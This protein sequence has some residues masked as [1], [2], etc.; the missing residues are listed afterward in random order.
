MESDKTREIAKKGKS[1]HIHVSLSPE[2]LA[3]LDVIRGDSGR[4]TLIK[5]AWLRFLDEVADGH[6]NPRRPRQFLAA[7]GGSNGLS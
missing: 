4:G 2:E 3:K 5:A 7:E 6:A 1:T